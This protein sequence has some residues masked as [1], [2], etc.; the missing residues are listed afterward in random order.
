MNNIV[1]ATRRANYYEIEL[2]EEDRSLPIWDRITFNLPRDTIARLI[3]PPGR[4]LVGLEARWI[5]LQYR[6]HQ[7]DKR[8][9]R[10]DKNG[11]EI[12][13]EVL[14]WSK[15]FAV[16]KKQFINTAR[17]LRK[18]IHRETIHRERT[19]RRNQQIYN[20]RQEN[21]KLRETLTALK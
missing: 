18:T 8:E 6:L 10:L 4:E 7:D 11:K 16:L 5:H 12:S 15:L 9:G 19:H 1:I 13:V 14:D 3:D 21:K 17:E 2:M 20:L